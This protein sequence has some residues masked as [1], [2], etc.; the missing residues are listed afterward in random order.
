[1]RRPWIVPPAVLAVEYG[2]LIA[3]TAALLWRQR[4]VAIE[5]AEHRA[6]SRA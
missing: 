4:I 6:D 1:L 3:A 5:S 2:L